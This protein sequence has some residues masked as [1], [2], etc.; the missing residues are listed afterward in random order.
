MIC[1]QISSLIG[2]SCHP[3]DEQG[4]IAL[5]ETPFIF[6]DGD[7]VPVFVERIGSRVRFFDDGGFYLHFRGRGV[8]LRSA[9]QT[10]FLSAAAEQHGGAFTK[11][12]VL[13]VWSSQDSAPQGFA[14]YI[15]AAMDL[16]RWES[17]HTGIAAETSLF[18]EEVA[19]CLAAWK[20][21][22]DIERRPKAQGITGKLHEFT[23]GIDGML[24]AAVGPHHAAISAAIHKLIDIKANPENASRK[25][26]V[27]LDNRHDKESSR[28]ES[29]VISGVSEVIEMTR[30]QRQSGMTTTLQ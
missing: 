3:L 9:A 4:Q 24:V 22:L 26:L 10:R 16:V 23:F 1:S 20:P 29:L 27:V 8:S 21:G 19:Q 5:I 7:E 11:E 18:I 12:G 17:A 25:T 6:N 2:F 14:R 13:E 30:L 28:R 15:G